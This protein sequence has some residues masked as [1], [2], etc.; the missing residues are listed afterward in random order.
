MATYQEQIERLRLAREAKEK[1]EAE[2]LAKQMTPEQIKN[3]RQVLAHMVGPYAYI[4]PDAMVEEF[5]DR[6][7]DRINAECAAADSRTKEKP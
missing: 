2:R 3:F 5:R 1:A 4:M 7:Q 6:I